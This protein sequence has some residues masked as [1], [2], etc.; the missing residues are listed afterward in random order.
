MTEKYKPRGG[1]DLMKAYRQAG[2][3]LIGRIGKAKAGSV[4]GLELQIKKLLNTV[5]LQLDEVN[6]SAL[7]QAAAEG[8][9][10]SAGLKA[11]EEIWNGSAFT[12]KDLPRGD[13]LTAEKIAA[14]KAKMLKDNTVYRA[15]FLELRKELISARSGAY[16]RVNEVLHSLSGTAENTVTAAKRAISQTFQSEGIL[17]VT[18]RNGAR[19]DV[20][21]YAAMV[22]RSA[23]TESANVA[24][25]QIA[26]SLGTNLVKC[27]GN[28]ITCKVCAMYRDRVFCTDGK[29]KR[30]PSLTV[31]QNAPLRHGY[32]LIHPNC[33]CEF[34]PY[35]ELLQSPE[36]LARDIARSNRPFKDDRTLAVKNAYQDW[37]AMNRQVREER[38]EFENMQAVLGD[39][40]PYETIGGYRRAVRQE[41]LPTEI[42]KFRSRSRDMAQYERW[43]KILG[44]DKMPGS[45]DK[46]QQLKYNNTEEYER[47]K[48]QKE[49][50][51]LDMTYDE[52]KEKVGLLPN[53]KARRWYN[54]NVHDIPNRIDMTKP[55]KEQAQ[56]ACDLRNQYR[57]QTRELMSD[58]ETKKGLYLKRPNKTLEELVERK[59]RKK[60]LTMEEAYWDIIETAS[61]T[62]EKVN[63]LFI[64]KEE[65]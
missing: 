37:Q 32:K 29:D 52:V 5:T 62:N 4:R 1:V 2:A 58:E 47:L 10:K 27:I 24:N 51:Y 59:M 11:L 33:R 56:Q 21:A 43:E 34:V 25:E 22:A 45:L 35:F 55:L 57:T 17:N 19:V 7:K 20:G 40:M 12:E 38:V 61:K 60:K 42:K 13:P 16:A 41:T 28:D 49:N 23:R 39:R 36:E 53:D 26:K 9:S 8:K 14:A 63:N 15:A 31:G 3:E 54:K 64:K 18:F 44:K 46:F 6:A 48:S 65:N 30:F 50:A